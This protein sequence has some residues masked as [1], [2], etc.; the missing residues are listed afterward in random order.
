MGNWRATIEIKELL[1]DYEEG[2]D[3]EAG[4]VASAIA[5]KLDSEVPPGI[6]NT[7]IDD[8][9]TGLKETAD[10]DLVEHEKQDEVNFILEALYDWGD[11]Q[12]VWLGF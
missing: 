5:A 10:A 6:R 11:S 7:E 1:R 8:I 2:K 12:R 9:I 3:G 4:R